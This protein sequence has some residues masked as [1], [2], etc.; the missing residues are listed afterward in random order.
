MSDNCWSPKV[1]NPEIVDDVALNGNA[2]ASPKFEFRTWVLCSVE[3]VNVKEPSHV[4][5]KANVLLST[6]LK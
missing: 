6:T 5:V 3:A 1:S 4:G 2:S